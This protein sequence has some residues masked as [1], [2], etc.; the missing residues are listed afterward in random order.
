MALNNIG[1]WVRMRKI[2]LIE[3]LIIFLAGLVPLLWLKPGYIIGN[4]DDFP[5]FLNPQNS[6]N[7]G[8]FLWSHNYLGSVTPTPAY[9][10]YLYPTALLNNLGVRSRICSNYL[11]KFF[12]LCL[13]AF[14]CIILRKIFILNINRSLL[15]PDFSIC[16]IFF[17]LI[18]GIT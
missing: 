7:T 12:C 4:G 5:L 13:P 8:L 6:I 17:L 1:K 10:L 14:Q 15:L 18:T 11:S 2:P 16:L 9:A 3:L